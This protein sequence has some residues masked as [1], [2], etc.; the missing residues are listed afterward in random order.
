[1][2]TVTVIQPK[3]DNETERLLRVAAYCRVSSSSDDQ[4][5]SY[6]AQV[7]YY[8]QKFE[9][10]KTETLVD[11]YADE[12]ISGTSETKR[13]DFQRLISDCR[14]GKIDRIYTKSISRFARNTRDCLKNI[15]ELKSIGVTIFFEKENIDTAKITDE[16]MITI[17]GGLAQEESTSI[18]QNLK[19]SIRRKMQNGTY[20]PHIAPFGYRIENKTLVVEESEAQIVREIFSYFINGHGTQSTTE[21]INQMYEIQPPLAIST[22]RYILINE[23][24]IGDTLCQKT[25]TPDIVGAHNRVNNGERDKF[26][27][28]N[29]HDAIISEETFY[30]AQRLLNCRYV[31]IPISRK[32]F[33]TGKIY[34]GKCGRKYVVKETKGKRNWSCTLHKTKAEWCDSASISEENIIN[35]FI[36][37][38]NKLFSNYN[39]LLVPILTSLQELELKKTTSDTNIIELRRNILQLKEQLNVIATLRTKGFISESKFQE[40][41]AEVNAKISKLNRDIQVLTASDDTT[42]KDMEMLIEYFE[43]RDKIMVEFELEAFEFLI[44]KIVVNGDMLDFHIMGGLVFS[45]KI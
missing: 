45:E 37:L 38:F 19:W 3:I 12:G 8:S 5:N 34:C 42:I 21:Y 36:R 33:L 30:I 15:R 26:Y 27:V 41:S 25:F 24:Y 13:L 2:P 7:N 31:T 16:L 29:T 28:K 11:I 39:N 10:S 23:K 4:L 17:M 6:Q 18:S 9:S 35:S 22:V 14:K 40:Q 43:N 32:C 20:C 44:D 1:M